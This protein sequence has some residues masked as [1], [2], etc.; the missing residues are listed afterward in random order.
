[1]LTG[2]EPF[3]SDNYSILEHEIKYKKINFEIIDDEQLR[4][5]IK[6]MMERDIKKRINAKEAY[7][8]VLKIKQDRDMKYE[9]ELDKLIIEIEKLNQQKE[10]YYNYMDTYINKIY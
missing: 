5:L 4:N 9:K 8:I 7:D 2:Y 10:K 1:M 6:K 3:K